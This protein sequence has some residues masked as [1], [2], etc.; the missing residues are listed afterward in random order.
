MHRYSA[1]ITWT[2]TTAGGYREYSRTHEA[3]SNGIALT[4]SADPFFRGDPAHVNP[5]QLLLMA[6]SSCQ[7]LSF[8]AIAAREG[9]TVT[10]YEDEATAKM[11]KDRITEIVLRP[12]VE[13]DAPVDELLARAH[14][15]CFIANTLNC[16]MRIEPR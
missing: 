15:E 7:L 11:P 14:E 10:A 3:T 12:R 16:E 9:V 13:A 1:T 4:M 2:G 8:L 6:A 5:E